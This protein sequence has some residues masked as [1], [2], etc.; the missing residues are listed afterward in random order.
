MLLGGCSNKSDEAYQSA[1][2]DGIEAVANEEYAKAEGFFEI[3]L[4]EK[5]DDTKARNYLVGI[6]TLHKLLKQQEEGNLEEGLKLSSTIIEDKDIPDAI[7]NEATKI[8]KEL[9]SIKSTFDENNKLYLEAE[10]LAK[11]QKYLESNEKLQVI[12]NKKLENSM[13]SDLMNKTAVLLTAN[14]D[15]LEKENSTKKEIE[16]QQETESSKETTAYVSEEGILRG[17]E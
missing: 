14:K 1:V 7:K 17:C 4:E 13:Y 6:E 2:T 8:K 12:Q 11:D 15:A 10:Q 9:N 3:A 16:A 5:S